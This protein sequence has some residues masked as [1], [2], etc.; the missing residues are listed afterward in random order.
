MTAATQGCTKCV[1]TL[2]AKGVPVS[3]KVDGYN[4]LMAAIENEHRY[5]ANNII[6]NFQSFIVTVTHLKKF[7]DY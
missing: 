7:S 1:K 2:L 4:C 5:I 6:T 3:E